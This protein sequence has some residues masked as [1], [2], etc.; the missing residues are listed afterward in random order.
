[1]GIRAGRGRRGSERRARDARRAGRSIAQ[2]LALAAVLAG[3]EVPTAEAQGI[4][5]HFLSV[6]PGD[7]S[8]GPPTEA[9]GKTTLYRTDL[10]ITG[11][12]EPE[13]FLT[14]PQSWT[15]FSGFRWQLYELGTGDSF[16]HLGTIDF[17]H[18]SA[19]VIEPGAIH[20]M[21]PPGPGPDSLVRYAW[22]G[23]SIA[24]SATIVWE[25]DGDEPREVAEFRQAETP[26]L[27]E[28]E[29]RGGRL[30]V[31]RDPLR[32]QVIRGL[33]PIGGEGASLSAAIRAEARPDLLAHVRRLRPCA[34]SDCELHLERIDLQ[35]DDAT[36]L[37][38]NTSQFTGSPRLVYGRQGDTYRFLGELP[39]GITWIDED[40]RVRV[41]D[42][43]DRRLLVY[44][45]ADEELVLLQ[46]VRP[47]P[48]P[49]NWSREVQGMLAAVKASSEA[50]GDRRYRVEWDAAA[51][52]PSAVPWLSFETREPA[53]IE[54]DLALPVVNLASGG[55]S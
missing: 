25:P 30:G 41:L 22:D 50:L 7:E 9:S 45:A 6:R 36:E 13:I 2:A 3:A 47:E 18:T 11:D 34:S 52:S 51:A 14:A 43:H 31:W 55:E 23:S 40:R 27:A 29:L 19:R 5:A 15:R 46:E 44:Q 10:D 42:M 37:V 24:A 32:Q 16:R 8:G 12:G 26:S 33:R 39:G 20:V 35:G 17:H 28:A 21:E 53:E 1:M 4:L 49:G 54:V 48:N 38:L